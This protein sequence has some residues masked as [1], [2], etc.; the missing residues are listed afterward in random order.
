MADLDAFIFG[1][2]LDGVCADYTLGLQGSVSA[3]TGRPRTDFPIERDWDFTQWGFGPGDFEYHH[4]RA[5]ATERMFRTLEVILAAEAL[6]SLSD[7]GVWIRVITH[8][9]YVNWG[10]RRLSPTPS[11]GSTTPDPLPRPV[12][13]GAK[14]QVEADLYIDDSPSNITG[15]RKAGNDVIVFDQPY[16]RDMAGP[17]AGNWS[18]V[19][20]IVMDRYT[21][22]SGVHGVQPVLPGSPAATDYTVSDPPDFGRLGS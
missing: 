7:A 5:V 8:R 10:I 21:A 15:L 19:E 6:W 14:P 16:N 17:R 11:P 3:H 4:R 13:L 20:E 18:E 9:L 12:F 2:D 22:W 1:V